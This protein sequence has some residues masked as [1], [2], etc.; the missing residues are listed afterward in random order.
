M[1]HRR[2]QRLQLQRQEVMKQQNSGTEYWINHSK[3]RDTAPPDS[4]TKHA[5]SRYRPETSRL[6]RLAQSVEV[7]S[8][9]SRTVCEQ[10]EHC[11]KNRL[12]S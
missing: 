11:S 8:A 6:R 9:G 12:S 3:T 10:E 5:V 1:V 7:R 4:Q 2:L